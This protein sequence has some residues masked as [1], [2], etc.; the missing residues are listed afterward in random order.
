VPGLH[1]AL[2]IH[3]VVLRDKNT[4]ALPHLVL[5]PEYRPFW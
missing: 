5:F 1:F 4:S 3:A 2:A